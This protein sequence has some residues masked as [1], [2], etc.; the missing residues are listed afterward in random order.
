MIERASTSQRRSIHEDQDGPSQRPS[1]PEERPTALAHV[2]LEM[3]M[4]KLDALTTEVRDYHG[5]MSL[6]LASIE[7]Q[8]TLR[9]LFNSSTPPEHRVSVLHLLQGTAVRSN[10]GEGPIG[11]SDP[12]KRMVST[13]SPQIWPAS[14]K[15]VAI[16][17]AGDESDPMTSGNGGTPPRQQHER[18][19]LATKQNTHL[20]HQRSH[21]DST[22]SKLTSSISKANND[23]GRCASAV[24]S[25]TKATPAQDLAAVDQQIRDPTS[26]QR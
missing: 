19:R 2:T 12:S 22:I 14:M 1:M 5:T 16:S 10:S 23:P 24:P 20:Q 8:R 15:K 9:A 7:N 11:R 13:S 18:G 26:H 3:I 21:P 17:L 25:K 6:K 4:A